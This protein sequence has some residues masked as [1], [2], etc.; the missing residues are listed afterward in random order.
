M[1]SS[2]TLLQIQ[3]LEWHRRFSDGR[4]SAEDDER[5][6]RVQTSHTAG[7]IEK[8]SVAVY[9][10]KSASQTELKDMAEN[11][12]QKCFDDLYKEWQKCVVARG[13]YFKGRCVL[14]N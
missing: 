7:N 5:S 13:S 2:D 14:A 1:H 12:S 3:A 10:I 6:E 8:L 4:E 11:G 9:E